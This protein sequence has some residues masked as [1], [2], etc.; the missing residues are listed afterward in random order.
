MG[1]ELQA[2]AR[3]T[4]RRRVEGVLQDGSIEDD[5]NGGDQAARRAQGGGHQE[6]RGPASGGDE[7]GD[8]SQDGAREEERPIANGRR[9]RRRRR[10]LVEAFVWA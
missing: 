3:G 2:A 9:Q 7:V 5:A 10:R 1:G 4:Q 8:N 6:L